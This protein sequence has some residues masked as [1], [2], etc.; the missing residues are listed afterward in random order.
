MFATIDEPPTLTN[1]KGIPVTGA[2]PIV[3]PTLMKIWTRSM[4]AM[5]PAAIAEKA[6]R[7]SVITLI[8]RQIT[9]R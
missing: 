9:S 5:P 7:A 8:A 6:S 1:G 4:T 3:I 2:I